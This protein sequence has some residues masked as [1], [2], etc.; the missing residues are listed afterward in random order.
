MNPICLFIF[1]PLGGLIGFLV[2]QYG[3]KRAIIDMPIITIIILA[4]AIIL[5]HFFPA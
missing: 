3:T 5:T 1:I 2:G 4:L